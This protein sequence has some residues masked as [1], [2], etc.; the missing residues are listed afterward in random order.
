[1]TLIP[2][3]PARGAASRLFRPAKTGVGDGALG[4]N[5]N[6]GIRQV[7]LTVEQYHRMIETGILAEGEPVELLG[8]ALVHKDR[9]AAGEDEMTVGHEHVL[10]VKKLARL[11]R[12]LGRSGCHMQTQQP[13]TIPD[14]DEPEPD[15]AIVA[16]EPDDYAGRLPGPG[17]VS[18]IIEVADS[19]LRIDRTVKLPVYADAGI[20]Q[21]VIVNLVDRV[22]EVYMRPLAGRGRYAEATTLRI[23]QRVQLLTSRSGGAKHTTN[24]K[25]K[26]TG[27]AVPVRS[28]LPPARRAG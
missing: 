19:S 7:P 14:F 17:D 4:A 11:D 15:G 28:L 21:Y 27:L 6:G 13:V 5:G 10:S 9:S 3:S 8:G 20:P 24:V 22:V 23:G 18:C 12:K 26:R 2:S 1:M 25:S 16:G